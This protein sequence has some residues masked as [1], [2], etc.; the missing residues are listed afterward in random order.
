MF[1]VSISI[2]EATSQGECVFLLANQ[3]ASVVIPSTK[4]IAIEAPHLKQ[5]LTL[6]CILKLPQGSSARLDLTLG[7]LFPNLTGEVDNWF[8][9]ALSSGTP[10][11]VKHP[12][13]TAEKRASTPNSLL[14]SKPSIRLVAS[15]S[16]VREG[17]VE[18]TS[19]VCPRCG[20]LSKIVS[21]QQEEI[22]QLKNKLKDKQQQSSPLTASTSSQPSRSYYTD[23]QDIAAVVKDSLNSMTS[24]WDTL[25]AAKEE[26]ERLKSRLG[27]SSNTPT[28][29]RKSSYRSRP[30]IDTEDIERPDS[31]YRSLSKR[32]L[33]DDGLNEIHSELDSF[34]QILKMLEVEKH[35]MYERMHGY[36]AE[37]K[38][39]QAQ[40]ETNRTTLERERQ[41]LA[42]T[43][44]QQKEDLQNSRRLA[45]K[46]TETIYGLEQELEDCRITLM[47]KDD[48]I[49]HLKDVEHC[50]KASE[51]SKEQLS[52]YFAEQLK[53]LE[54][55]I[56]GLQ[57]ENSLSKQE[58]L[59]LV[60]TVRSLRT[61]IASQ[62]RQLDDI[63]SLKDE[64]DARIEE[65]ESELKQRKD[66]QHI[67][68]DLQHYMRLTDRLQQELLEEMDSLKQRVKS[69]PNLPRIVHEP[70][71][72]DE[73][74]QGLADYLNS[75]DP[76]VPV[77]FRREEPGV[78]FFGTKKVFI[79]IEQGRIIIRVGGGFM[80]IEEFIDIYTP[81]EL[82]KNIR[83]RDLPSRESLVSKLMGS[84][85]E[86]T[87]F[88]QCVG[89]QRKSASPSK[90]AKR[91][92][93]PG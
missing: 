41:S 46:H 44:D 15:I 2:P 6:R 83:S 37:I 11:T 74:D 9:L 43:L 4:V 26:L 5:A 55:Q 22:S 73:V 93:S 19:E 24:K 42:N 47:E 79:K 69:Q 90:I 34:R 30:S 35:S 33:Q 45:E 38:E 53:R 12:S 67:Q 64:T 65:L 27:S 7:D 78:Y 3:V 59:D 66:S 63:T 23:G 31:T 85:E 60:Q 39:W 8:E 82:E 1:R 86:S 13:F 70:F 25:Q 16:R 14:N 52:K 89:L 57:T 84:I 49:V 80:R 92:K 61:Q 48:E 18:V 21:S 87:D 28:S 51:S 68:E 36:I 20:A 10:R 32:T 58:N 29:A 62:Q 81:I 71:R 72:G 50:L 54:E 88:V 17:F 75:K 76:P 40:H 56:Q 77:P 91:S